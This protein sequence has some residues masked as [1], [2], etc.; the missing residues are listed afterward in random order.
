[1]LVEKGHSIEQNADTVSSQW[2]AAAGVTV[3]RETNLDLVAR[4]IDNVRRNS[5]NPSISVMVGGIL[6]KGRPDLIVRVGADAMAEDGPTAV[7]LARRL[8]LE[9]SA[10]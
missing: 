7:L 6:F 1:M 2:I 8:Y 3:S 5:L 10:A 4:T 9:Q